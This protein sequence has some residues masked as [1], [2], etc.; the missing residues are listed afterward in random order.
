MSHIS[1][2]GLSDCR[3]GSG[4]C[5]HRSRPDPHRV[6][7]AGQVEGVGAGDGGDGGC[8]GLLFM[9]ACHDLYLRVVGVEPFFDQR[10]TLKNRGT[11]FQSARLQ[12]AS[13]RLR[14]VMPLYSDEVPW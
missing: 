10:E 9:D 7:L 11:V 6:V 14:D 4:C 12:K 8:D 3:S 5:C 13:F 1:D 2:E